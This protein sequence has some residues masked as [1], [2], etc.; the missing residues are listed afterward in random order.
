MRK[1]SKDK[2]AD[3][4]NDALALARAMSAD[5]RRRFWD[6]LCADPA[7]AEF[8]QQLR[9][10]GMADMYRTM[11]V[12]TRPQIDYWMKM[13]PRRRDAWVDAAI[14]ALWDEGLSRGEIAMKL[15]LPLREVKYVIDQK[16]KPRGRKRR[17]VAISRYG[18]NPHPARW[19]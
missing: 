6:A 7:F 8:A 17:I 3:P 11:V 4:V 15:E 18:Y 1:K 19:L 10:A 16:G 2:P 12:L 5:D 14:I 9:A 13:H